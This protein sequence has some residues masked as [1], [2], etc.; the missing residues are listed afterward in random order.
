MRGHIALIWS[1]NIL[2]DLVTIL[3]LLLEIRYDVVGAILGLSNEWILIRSVNI[4]L[5]LMTIILSSPSTTWVQSASTLPLP[6]IAQSDPNGGHESWRRC[7]LDPIWSVLRLGIYTVAIRSHVL[8]SIC[9]HI[10][11][12]Y[13]KKSVWIFYRIH[14]TLQ[15]FYWKKF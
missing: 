8:Y 3:T 10:I 5:H 4:I 1:S 6:S 2:I 7:C 12:V 14:R 15:S 11:R 9:T 13:I